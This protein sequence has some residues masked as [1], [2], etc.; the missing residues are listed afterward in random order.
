MFVLYFLD[1]V[2]KIGITKLKQKNTGA[3]NKKT[4]KKNFMSPQSEKTNSLI[5]LYQKNY[6]SLHR[7][8]QHIWLNKMFDPLFFGPNYS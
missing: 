6:L 2:E 3:A 1:I 8:Q 4:Q 5:K 7:V